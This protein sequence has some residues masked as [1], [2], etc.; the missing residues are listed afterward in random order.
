MEE[1]NRNPQKDRMLL[2]FIVLLLTLSMITIF[3]TSKSDNTAAS[4]DTT[5]S[6][7]DTNKNVDTT[8]EP[9]TEAITSADTDSN[10]LDANL[11]LQPIQYTEDS[12]DKNSQ[13]TGKRIN[14]SVTGLDGRVGRNSHLAD[15]NHVISVFTETGEILITSIPRDTYCDLGYEDSTN[16]NKLTICRS[17]KG[18][19]AYHK[20]LCRIAGVN[21]IDYWVEFGFSQAMGIIEFLG[22][23]D[24]KNTLQV[25]R[26]RKGLGGDDYQRCYTQGQFIR[27]AL[28]GHFNKFTGTL[29]GVLARAGLLLVETNLT[30]DVALDIIDKLDKVGFPKSP[31]VI[32]VQVKPNVNIKYKIY[33]FNNE[34]TVPQLVNKIE[35]FN[36]KRFDDEIETAQPVRNV[37]KIL[38]DA[39]R[40]AY[41]DTAKNPQRVINKLV[42]YY[43]QRAWYQVM[44]LNERDRI[45]SEFGTLLYNAY[46]KRGK[47]GDADKVKAVIEADKVLHNK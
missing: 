15:A 25:L 6:Q 35:R 23:K 38:D 10:N 18:R 22:F 24:P 40:S 30:N 14:I 8:P 20:E 29:G 28:L 41:L 46:V 1:Q 21:K 39:L 27:Q 34:N 33:D 45:R 13:Y 32:R 7:I 4:I 19:S 42:T 11:E 44:D 36:K 37:Q 5:T 9:P 16:L 12:N 26:N 43:N 17:N 2:F 31:D 3:C 47:Q